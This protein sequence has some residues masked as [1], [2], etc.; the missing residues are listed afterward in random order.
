MKKFDDI[1]PVVLHL[2][3]TEEE[4]AKI[5]LRERRLGLKDRRKIPTYIAND[6]RCGIVDRRKE[7]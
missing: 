2:E 7:S 5:I 4:L 6:R 1:K 3:P